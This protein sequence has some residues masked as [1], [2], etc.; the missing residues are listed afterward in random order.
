MYESAF[1]L[2]EKPF[3][4]TPDP[5]YLFLSESHQQALDHLLFGLESGDGFIVVTGEVGVGKT[6]VCRA[7]LRRLSDRY[8]TSIVLNPMLTEKE[9]I[10][11]ILE[12]FGAECAGGGTKKDHLD[13][14]D[15][16]LLAS[17]EAGKR[18]VLIID[19][20]Q[21]LTPSLLEQVR[22]L[23]NLETEKR[24]LIQIVLI[25]QRELKEKLAMDAL[26]Q[27]DQR[28]TVRAQIR[29]LD[30]KAMRR[31]VDHRL[32][33]AGAG[34]RQLVT[35][36]AE[37]ALFRCSGGVPRVVNMLC[38]RAFLSASLRNGAAIDAADV[39]RAA[40]SVFDRGW[41][42]RRMLRMFPKAAAVLAALAV[43]AKTGRGA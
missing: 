16:F 20:A 28:V 2:T 33:V 11:G 25:G 43:A 42:M 30:R 17:A 31:Y 35:D 1:G 18:P 14:L 41:R 8:V 21:D 7:L 24:K 23:S 34:G 27:L 19:E 4:L 3:S 29:P 37:R 5:D 12:D 6:T 10:R 39:R 36:G 9:L 26:R 38:D 32:S 13:A 22:L 40:D 15:R